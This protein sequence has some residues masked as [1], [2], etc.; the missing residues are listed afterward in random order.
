MPRD[1]EP[2]RCRG[3]LQ[4]ELPTQPA[5]LLRFE[6]D[7]ERLRSTR[8]KLFFILSDLAYLS[9]VEI[10]ENVALNFVPRPFTTA[11]IATEMPAAISPYSMA[12]A[13]VSSLRKEVTRFF[14]ANSFG[15]RT[16]LMIF[17][18]P[19]PLCRANI[20]SFKGA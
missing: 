10:D 14:I 18:Q 8:P 12:V 20:D 19:L 1:G 15:P 16:G 17:A 3:G 9:A 6:I 7:E 11:M 2:D 4:V 5:D 13:A